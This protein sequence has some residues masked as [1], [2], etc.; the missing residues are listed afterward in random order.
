MTRAGLGAGAVL[1]VG[2]GLATLLAAARS[3]SAT[4]AAELVAIAGGVVLGALA[5]ALP[6]LIVLRRRT[7]AAQVVGLTLAVV[8][9][10]A[11]GTYVAA[12]AMFISQHD[13]AVVQVVLVA[14]AAAGL[15][16]AILLGARIS[17]GSASLVAATR[18]I[19]AR[20]AGDVGAA[21]RGPAE[22]VRLHEALAEME[23][24]LAAS[25]ARERAT[26]ASRRE[27]VAWVS[28]DLRTPL[29][30]LRAM[31]EAVEDG[32]VDDPATI[33]RYHATMR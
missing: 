6:A 21:P 8:L 24:R 14:A 1:V 9:S 19:G 10:I 7:S 33:A 13:L 28:H 25:Q 3:M 12:E 16:G 15:A 29:A 32:V 2:L 27:L 17:A 22:L 31:V 11:L 26:E 23:E 5:V 4:D 30:A 20:E 18:R